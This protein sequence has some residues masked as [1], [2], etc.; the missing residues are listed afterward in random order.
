MTTTEGH[1]Q[2]H[3]MLLQINPKDM[4]SHISSS[5]SLKTQNQTKK[6]RLVEV[7]W[8]YLKVFE[9]MVTEIIIQ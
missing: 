4:V 3:T 2:P 9:K 6:M 1:P 7:F 8:C 5:S